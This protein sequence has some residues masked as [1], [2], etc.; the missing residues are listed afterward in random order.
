MERSRVGTEGPLVV[1][2]VACFNQGKF[3][4]TAVGSALRQSYPNLRVILIDDASTD[5]SSP[6]LCRALASERVE[7]VCLPE[8]KGRALVRNVGLAAAGD[9]DFL[10]VLDC[11][12]AL[13]H[14]YVERLVTALLNDSSL[15]LVYGKLRYTDSELEP[16]QKEWPNQA[17]DRQRMYLENVIP[18]PGVLFR[19]SA[20]RQTHG[21]RQEFNR[22]SGEDYDI[23][24]QVVEQGWK[25][26]WVPSAVYLYRQH[27]ESFL[28]SSDAR[29]RQL[30]VAINILSKHLE[31]IKRSVGV[32]TYCRYHF[33]SDFL[34]AIRY[35]QLGGAWSLFRL[36]PREAKLATVS[37]AIKYFAGRCWLRIK[38]ARP[39]GSK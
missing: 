16:A 4:A 35:A 23:W 28:S 26:A 5:G 25:V 6:S 27:G 15:G 37:Y 31:G 7:V 11:D 33:M 38:R 24:L 2:L 39:N 8:N 18:G 1:V 12:D 32:E 19:V 3:A 34:H 20:L 30:H 14:D 22:Y 10:L 29:V 9:Q 36:L 21:W 17:F 13:T